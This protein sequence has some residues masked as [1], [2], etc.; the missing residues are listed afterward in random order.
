[1]NGDRVQ[2]KKNRPGPDRPEDC[3]RARDLLP[4]RVG[5]RLSPE[6]ESRVAGH[7]Q[8]CSGCAGEMAFLVRLQGARPDPGPDLARAVLRD[9]GREG[10]L[11]GGTGSTPNRRRHLPVFRKSAWA[12]RAAAVVILGLGAGLLWQ[13]REA[14]ESVWSLAL[15]PQHSDEYTGMWAGDEWMVAGEPLLDELPDEVLLALLEDLQ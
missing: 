13:G 2:G 4:L 8:G 12:L 3:A 5:G 6:E 11:R 15:D 9:L 10:E 1:M 14:P 7:L